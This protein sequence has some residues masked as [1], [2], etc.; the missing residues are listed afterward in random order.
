M[1]IFKSIMGYVLLLALLSCTEEVDFSQ[2]EDVSL[3]PSVELAMLYVEAPEEDIN[4]SPDTTF[5]DFTFSFLAFSEQYVSE[6]L[7]E[8]GISYQIEN[9]TSKPL[10]ITIDFID[11][12]G[13]VLDT[14]SFTIDSAPTDILD[15]SVVYGGGGKSLDILRNTVTLRVVGINLGDSTSVS[16]LPNPTVVLRSS[17]E[18]IIRLVR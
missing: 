8:G 10:Q 6:N 5:F 11:V 2:Y 13:L 3:T 16:G 1:K 18:F 4:L 12:N 15:R 14:E 17:A 9:T 7:V